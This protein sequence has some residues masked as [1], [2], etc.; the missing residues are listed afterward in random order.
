MTDLINN[1]LDRFENEQKI[2]SRLAWF[3]FCASL[4]SVITTIMV[5]IK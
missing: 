3:C 5:V 1:L 4:V 2:K